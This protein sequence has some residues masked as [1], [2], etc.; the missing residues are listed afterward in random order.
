MMLYELHASPTTGHFGF[1]KTYERVKRSFFWDGM[2]KE[3]HT[4]VAECVVC[5]CNKGAI[6]KYLGTLQPFF[7]PPSIWR[8]I[9]MDFIVGLPKSGNKSDIMVV[10]YRLSKYSHFCALQHPF[11]ESKVAHIFMDHIFKLHGMPH[12]IVFD[13]DPTFTINFWE[14]QFKLQGTQ[15]HLSTSYHP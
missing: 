9:S 5:Q 7:I 2:K 15:L 3:I 10:V 6:F 12:S 11:K 8:E 4:F 13:R 1:T 14:E